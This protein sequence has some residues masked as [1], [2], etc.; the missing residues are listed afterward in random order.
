MIFVFS[1]WLTSLTMIIS[2]SIHV[3]ANGTI[4]F[5]FYGGVIFYTYTYIHPHHIFSTSLLMD[6]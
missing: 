4:S 1:V 2:G 3:A 6:I 5:G